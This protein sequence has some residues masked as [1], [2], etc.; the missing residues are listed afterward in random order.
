MTRSVTVLDL[1]VARPALVVA[2]QEYEPW[3]CLLTVSSSSSPGSTSHSSP[4]PVQHPVSVFSVGVTTCSWSGGA[5]GQLLQQ[6]GVHVPADPGQLQ[7]GVVA[8]P[9]PGEAAH[10]ADVGGAGLGDSH[11]PLALVPEDGDGDLGAGHHGH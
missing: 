7:L 5:A 11:L 1:A 4:P 2:E 10:Q 6:Q 8:V 9:L 3:K